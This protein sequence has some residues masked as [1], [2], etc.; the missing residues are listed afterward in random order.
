MI[1]IDPTLGEEL[2]SKVLHD[3]TLMP[4]EKF[5][6]TI[7]RLVKHI[8]YVNELIF[9]RT[10]FLNFFYPCR[11]LLTEMSQRDQE[12]IEKDVEITLV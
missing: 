7:L 3:F 10:P 8:I 12:L 6:V 4:E 11:E 1:L 5:K 9:D 2:V